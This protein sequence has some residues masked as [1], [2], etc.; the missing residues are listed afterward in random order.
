VKKK[1]REKNNRTHFL[2]GDFSFH[3]NEFENQTT[4]KVSIHLQ[5]LLVKTPGGDG[6]GM[7]HLVRLSTKYQIGCWFHKYIQL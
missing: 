1:E 4:I 6:E 5:I 3:Q 2:E 7:V